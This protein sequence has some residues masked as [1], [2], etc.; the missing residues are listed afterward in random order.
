MQLQKGSWKLSQ[1]S[2][3]LDC[4][5]TPANWFTRRLTGGCITILKDL[6][7][8]T[9]GIEPYLVTNFI[10]SNVAHCCWHLCDYCRGRSLEKRRLCEPLSLMLNFLRETRGAHN[11]Y[12]QVAITHTR[13]VCSQL[14]FHQNRSKLMEW[15]QCNLI[16]H[17]WTL[18]SLVIWLNLR[19][20][21]I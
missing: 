2:I 21:Q 11:P 1:T 3:F 10:C 8:K 7:V 20:E 9:S 5:I 19:K 12:L 13:H 14:D 15:I 4:N 6:L 17:S 16:T 18:L